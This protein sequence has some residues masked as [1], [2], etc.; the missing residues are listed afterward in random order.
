MVLLQAALFA[1]IVA[2]LFSFV[3]DEV[4][5]YVEDQSHRSVEVATASLLEA[6][7]DGT[8]AKQVGQRATAAKAGADYYLVS[9]SEGRRIAGNLVF[10]PKKTGWQTATLTGARG[11]HKGHAHHVELLVTR[12]ADGSWLT[13]GRD[14]RDVGEL[15]EDL[16][17]FFRFS[18]GGMLAFALLF[19]AVAGLIFVRRVDRLSS[20]AERIV[21][22]EITGPL[23]HP[24]RGAE[25]ARLAGR[26]N[27]MLER[28]AVL[29]DNMRQV[30]NDIAH[31]LRTPLTRLRQRLE[32]AQLGS[33]DAATLRAAIDHS[34]TDVDDV[35]T[36]FG[37]LLRISRIEAR[38]RQAGFAQLNLSELFASMVEAYSPVAE[39]NG[40]QVLSDI[41]P[42]IQAR[43]DRALLAQMLSNLIENAIHH[44]PAGARIEVSLRNDAKGLVGCVED[45]GPGIP[46]QHHGHVFRRF[47]RL[48]SSR[49]SAG[50]GLG[51]ALVAAVADLHRVAI[52]LYDRGPGLSVQMRFPAT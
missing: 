48:D 26:L 4:R 7:P 14:N 45:N 13:V 36:T 11:K 30:S 16:S 51:L 34:M 3:W 6:V 28:I 23:E 29:M 15:D 19:G 12:L 17:R 8:L 25:F 33:Q 31:D 1:L 10:D 42:D 50:S 39:D 41:A 18:V 24:P 37:A 52:E 32:A 5:T 22:G 9:N 2:G 44:T 47:F 49:T 40:K 38:E 27:T 21:A 43:G 20:Q 46:Q 35:L